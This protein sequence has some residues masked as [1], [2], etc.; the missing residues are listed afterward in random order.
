MSVV[1]PISY[2]IGFITMLAMDYFWSSISV[3]AFLLSCCSF[4]FYKHNN[5]V[6]KQGISVTVCLVIL[7]LLT[8]LFAFVSIRDGQAVCQQS[9]VFPYQL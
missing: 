1:M 6:G 3:T 9:S 8:L 2:I 4:Y 5:Y 7:L